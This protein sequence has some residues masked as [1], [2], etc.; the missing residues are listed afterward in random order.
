MEKAARRKTAHIISLLTSLFILF[1][2]FGLSPAGGQATG[3][4]SGTVYE[5]G[6]TTPIADIGVAV[7][8]ADYSDYGFSSTDANGNYSVTGLS[9]GDYYVH[10][11]PGYDQNYI[12]EYYDNTA[13]IYNA[14]PVTIEGEAKAGIDFYLDIG[15][16]I[17]GF[18]YESNGTTPIEGIYIEAYSDACNDTYESYLGYA[19]TDEN[20]AY[21]INGLS[22]GSA[23]IQARALNYPGEPVLNFVTEWYDNADGTTD[24]NNAVSI[25]VTQGADTS[26]YN[27][28]LNTGATISG[29]VYESD[30]TTP[31]EGVYIYAFSN[32]CDYSILSYA[33]TDSNGEY[34]FAGL[35]T[36]DV[37]LAAV[38]DYD[39]DVSYFEEYYG[40]ATDCSGAKAISVNAGEDYAGKDFQ[41]D[42][43]GSISGII[44]ESD[45]VTPIA[46]A[47]V[48]A[49]SDACS[50]DPGAP[51]L[52]IT[53]SDYSGE[54]KLS[55]LSSGNVYVFTYGTMPAIG[56]TPEYIRN[57][58]N[59]AFSC[60]DA[61]PVAVTV[62]YDTGDIDFRLY[63]TTDSDTDNMPDQ[64]EVVYFGDLSNDGFGDSDNDGVS[65]VD[66]YT[67]GTAPREVY[68]DDQTDDNDE[69]D[70]GGGGGGGI[71]GAISINDVI[72]YHPDGITKKGTGIYMPVTNGFKAL[73]GAQTHVEGFAPAL[74]GLIRRCFESIERIAEPDKDGI[75]YRL[76]TYAFPVLG[77]IAELYLNAVG[78][79]QLMTDAYSDTMIS[80]AEFE[81]LSKQGFAISPHIVKGEAKE[82]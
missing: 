41:L 39:A 30:G 47:Q 49:M 56:G 59:N 60:D 76:G 16:S 27:F 23:F 12:G 35:S 29:T 4:I 20:G 28:R 3:S 69:D 19:F 1:I 10:V 18:V 80:M 46:G 2:V 36:G 54:Y 50:N 37:Y 8:K 66:E 32:A 78:A 42:R 40:G 70:D 57:W 43:A 61:T 48:I 5:S 71:F 51:K 38:S 74:A 33:V 81:R 55:N 64:W 53:H 79:E 72:G 11:Y 82:P 15:G 68:T 52:D 7:Y 75:L 24:C 25:S 44:Y 17:S 58:Y 9:A 14:D 22:T 73:K 13:S 31:V 77:R 26:N 65:D 63:P 67:K 45:G 62:G 34:S 6:T 21:T